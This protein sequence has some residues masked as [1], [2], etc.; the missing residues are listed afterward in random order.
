MTN[1]TTLTISQSNNTAQ[2][3]GQFDLSSIEIN[4]GF[5]NLTKLA[6]SQGKD[7]R[8]YL[9]SK[10]GKE[11][12]E[13]YQAENP[14]VQIL[15]IRKGDSSTIEQG[16]FGTREL[17]LEVARWISPKFSVWC[18]KQIDTLL[19]TGKVELAQPQS[20]MD[21]VL[22]FQQALNLAVETIQEKDL[23][24]ALQAPK[25]SLA[26]TYLV[27]GANMNLST[28]AKTL[29]MKV[30]NLTAL[31]Y[32]KPYIFESRGNKVPYSEYQD[33]FYCKPFVA[34]NGH[35]GSQL[36]VTPIGFE[37]LSKILKPK[38]LLQ[39]VGDAINMIIN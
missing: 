38:N 10:G 30:T 36:L 2:N 23:Q 33:W 16:T 9:R 7:I 12:I 25:V 5:V 32:A 13:C 26:D 31:L 6:Q 27:N 4:N 24:L 8:A 14:D 34:N 29:N 17:A 35:S 21:L 28:C 20:K 3:Q 37:K 22:Q 1:N 15:H 39:K 19:Q 11:F 18:A